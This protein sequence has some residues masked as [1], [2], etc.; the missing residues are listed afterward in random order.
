MTDGVLAPIIVPCRKDDIDEMLELEWLLTNRIGA[1]A[2]ST[3]VG[4]N[5]RRYHGLLVAA[6]APPVCRELALSSIMEQLVLD[7]TVIDLGANEFGGAFSPRGFE[8][9]VEFRNDA[10][11]TFV[12]RAGGVELTKEV[13]LAEA[14]NSVAVRYTVRGAGA[15]KVGLRLWPFVAMRDFHGLRHVEQPHRMTYETQDGGIAVQDRMRHGHALHVVSKEAQ[16]QGKP[17]WWY[18]FLY[19]ADLA[20]GQDGAE[21]LYTPGYFS[22]EL[23][24]GQS[25]QITAS[26]EEPLPLGFR[27]TLDRR[28]ARLESLASS[29]GPTADDCTRRLAVAGDAFVVTRTFAS[30]PSATI[31]AGYHWFADWGRDTFISLPGLLLETE[32]YDL[33]Q[34]V[35]RTFAAHVSQGM[36]PNRFDDYLPVAHYNSID[37]SLWYIMAA[38]RY[39]AATGDRAMWR[40]VLM[41]TA[42]AILGA[43]QD[44]TMFDIHADADGLLMGGTHHTQLTWMDAKLGQEVVTPRHG[45]PVEVNALWYAA[46]R[47][48]AHR[49]QDEDPTLA[50]HCE[51][52]AA[53]IAPAFVRAFWNPQGDWLYDCITD[54]KP[55]AALRPNQ[56]LAVSLPYSPL[57]PAQQRSVVAAVQEHLLTPMGLR[58]LSPADSRYR[59]ACAGSWESRDRAYHQGTVWAWLM[60]PFIEAYLKVEEYRPLAVKQAQDWL[61]P[62][63]EHIAR[64]GVGYISE[65][66]DG[67]WPHTPRGCI[68]QAWS[69]AELLR[70]K[71]LLARYGG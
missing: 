45:K 51:E 22:Y 27:T 28:R 23:G 48:L 5:T 6:T 37:A 19:R 35:F 12:Y 15:G 67:D 1:Y 57:A 18:R 60:G 70:I 65:I 47:I 31:I 21:D 25:C 64:A 38:E 54:G 68:A 69:V 71:R 4:C 8:H 63:E 46:H 58:T 66:F 3:V 44:G 42:R 53:L 43:Y 20:R 59:R 56:I 10:A 62:L 11:P 50:R 13:L 29:V 14:A 24:E 52:R 30:T 32:R 39:L 40:Q 9:L 7:Q 41:P 36:V 55:D 17:Q 26:M 61:K 16:F 33:A 49:C 34:Q 2:S